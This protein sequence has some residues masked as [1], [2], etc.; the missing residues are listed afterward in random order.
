MAAL[1]S[2]YPRVSEWVYIGDT[3]IN[4]AQVTGIEFGNAGS[5]VYAIV[6]LSSYASE[7]EAGDLGKTWFK[8][9]DPELVRFLREYVTH[10]AAPGLERVRSMTATR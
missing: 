8:V 2:H 7:Y 5:G 4:M 10:M 1:V 3:A 9:R 6:R